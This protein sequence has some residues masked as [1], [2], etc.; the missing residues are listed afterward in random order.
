MDIFCLYGCIYIYKAVRVTKVTRLQNEFI[1]LCKGYRM[2]MKKVNAYDYA[3]LLLKKGI[4][5]IPLSTAS[6]QKKPL[7]SFKDIVINE[8]FININS[9]LY[10]R[11]NMLGVL[12]R[13]VWCL[14]ID[15][16]DGKNGLIE[17]QKIP[18]YEELNRNFSRTL[19]QQTPSGGIHYI[20][21]KNEGIDY[22]QKIN[23][24]DGIDIKAHHNNYFVLAGSV[25]EKGIYR[26]NAQEPISYEGEF[27]K[28]IFNA[29][30]SYEEQIMR[31]YSVK[32]R[33][34]RYDYSHLSSAGKGGKGKEAYERIIKGGSNFRNNDLFL[35]SSYAISCG[36]DLEPLRVLIGDSSK[37]HEVT[38]AEFNATVESAYKNN[39]PNSM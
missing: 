29:K 23:Y 4:Q 38:E 30:G 10:Q 39:V 14:D 1:G 16:K 19:K 3:K 18:Y 24:L 2:E 26:W 36:I 11:S 25:T 5:T 33:L 28:R 32:K 20:F 27:E 13:D 7:L 35:A 17:L 34:P 21:K 6:G 22:R 8:R 31:K 37:D 15:I 9:Q 12:T